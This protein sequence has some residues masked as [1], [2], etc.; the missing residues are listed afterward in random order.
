MT[1]TPSPEAGGPAYRPVDTSIP[2]PAEDVAAWL[3]ETFQAPDYTPPMLP[4]V[5]VRLLELTRTPD[6][7]VANVRQLLEQDS[8]L[9]AATLQVANSATP[10]DS[11]ELLSIDGAIACLGMRRVTELFLETAVNV[12]VFRAPGY[13]RTMDQL[14]LHSAATAHLTRMLS[15]YTGLEPSQG[16]VCGLL[17][18]VGLAAGFIAISEHY[19]DSSCPPADVVWPAVL[20]HHE[21]A[22]VLLQRSW[23]LPKEIGTVLGAHH[24]ESEG[25]ELHPTAAQVALADA[26]TTEMDMG[27]RNEVAPATL[28]LARNA[29]GLDEHT[30]ARVRMNAEVV[31]SELPR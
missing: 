3:L 7:N 18:D 24:Y 29:L 31:L 12:K 13:D 28:V 9:T 15:N 25:Q 30:F 16:F 6:V 10:R 22:N 8:M 27:M 20:Q 11:S 26:L 17:H 2:P 4:T 19:A 1:S 5:A 14:R 23:G 21:A